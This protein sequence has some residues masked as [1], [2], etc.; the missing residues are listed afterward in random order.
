MNKRKF[1]SFYFVYTLI[2]VFL[3]S[4]ILFY[5]YSANKT[6]IDYSGDGFRQHFRAL[7]Y[8][9]RYFKEIFSNIFINHSFT[10]PQWDFS[11]GE[12]N[13]IITTFH[14]YGLGDIFTFFSCLFPEKYMHRY[15]DIAVLLR[16]YFSGITFANLCI[17]KKKEDTLALLS[18]SLLYAFCNFSLAAVSGHSFFASVAVFLPMIIQGVEMIINHDRPY[19]LTIGV[20]LSAIGNI[21]FFYMNVISTVI[22]TALR[23][24]FMKKSFKESISILLMITIYSLFGV[25]IAGVIVFPMLYAML[26]GSR[27]QSGIINSLFYPMVNYIGMI[28][29]YVFGGFG[30]FGGFSLL[31]LIVTIYILWKKKFNVLTVLFLI[32]II[33][34]CIPFFG[35]LY[36]AMIYPTDRWMYALSMLMSYLI[37]DNYDEIN[38]LGKDYIVY[39][40]ISI[41]YYL[42]CLY[43][44]MDQWQIFAMF[45][46][47]TIVYIVINRFYKNRIV[48]KYLCLFL[49]VFSILFNIL[50]KY[51]PR[52][53]YITDLGT[54]LETIESMSKEEHSVLDN[55][56]ETFFRYS[57]DSLTTNQSVLGNNSSTQFY[58]SIANDNVIDFRKQLGLSD[59]NNH[60]YDH[61]DDRFSLNSL[62]SVRYFFKDDKNLLPYGYNQEIDSNNHVYK[63]DYAQ[64]LMYVYDSYILEEEWNKLKEIDKNEVLAQ[65]AV[66]DREIPTINHT[67]MKFSNKKVNYVLESDDGISIE[68]GAITVS[69]SNS[70]IRLN[71]KEISSGEYYVV[72]NGL[73][74]DLNTNIIVSCDGINKALYYKG[75]YHFAYPDKHDFMINIGYHES[76]DD[77]ITITF[78]NEGIFNY[79]SISVYC[80]PLDYQI[81]CLNNLKNFKMNNLSVF[82]NIVEGDIVLNNDGLLCLS[83]PYSKGWKAYLDGKEVELMK[84]NI[85]YMAINVPGGSHNIK[86]VYSTPLLKFGFIVSL[87]SLILYLVLNIKY[88]IYDRIGRYEKK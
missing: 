71:C 33:F 24:L 64:E 47:V 55:R 35:R 19:L 45:M 75:P 76:F 54:D 25:L 46:I 48:V 8:C 34:S 69:N 2:F 1:Y 63:S 87:L 6:L 58:W 11:I 67:D 10:I 16:L 66:I 84:C 88:K 73:Y 74:S 53:W 12:G 65:G 52:W 7:I 42:F 22:Y 9:S 20:F 77:V 23:I 32:G 28:K 68:N 85:Q 56:K 37:V 72:I 80:Q 41:V 14:Y 78:L 4:F 62:A 39:L 43:Y 38:N 57:G 40:V 44:S 81:E 82:D 49:V 59:H 50:Y 30:Y 3:V 29:G 26:S 17:Y 18:G 61:Y 60:H 31:G 83:I 27:L 36:N 13:D 79:S 21:Y 51:S 70:S 86:L 5:H 15:Y